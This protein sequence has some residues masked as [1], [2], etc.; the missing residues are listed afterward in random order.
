MKAEIKKIELNKLMNREYFKIIL[1][2]QKKELILSNPLMS[3]PINFRKQVFGILTAC[4]CYDLMRLATENPIR[5]KAIGYYCKGA[6]YRIL[7]NMDGKWLLLDPKKGMYLY[8][9]AE[10][11]TKEL[12][13][14]A[15]KEHIDTISMD[16]GTIESIMSASSIFSILFKG[17]GGTSSSMQTGQL[18]YGFGSPINIGNNASQNKKLKSAK[19]FKS[20]IVC[21]MKLFNEKDLL[22]LGGNIEK[23]P[24]VEI[25]LDHTNKVS[26][27]RN[28]ITGLGF[29]IGKSYEIIDNNSIEN[30]DKSR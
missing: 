28:P 21:L 13:K 25:T 24:E 18:Y 12:I 10:N 5:P 14:A 9:N 30:A 20:F 11:E 26:S 1:E 4:N 3:D 23:Y 6:G 15:E 8:K 2:S 27:I 19:M 7:E 29:S 22:K 17:N 16:E